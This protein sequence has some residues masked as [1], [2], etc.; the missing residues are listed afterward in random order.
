MRV[1]AGAVFGALLFFCVGYYLA[2]SK[3]A[4]HTTVAQSVPAPV[5]TAT[6]TA[7]VESPSIGPADPTHPYEAPLTD[8]AVKIDGVRTVRTVT[9]PQWG[10]H[11]PAGKYVVIRLSLRNT[12]KR[13]VY[14]PVHLPLTTADGTDFM[15]TWEPTFGQTVLIGHGDLGRL[16]PGATTKV[17]II[18]DVPKDAVPV[19]L[20]GLRLH[21]P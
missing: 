12:T 13:L 1:F 11:H 18:Y 14:P 7:P 19:R 16:N 17:V 8:F 15:P 4:P 3:P 9:D 21:R 10:T 20:S 6:A 5:S 2:G